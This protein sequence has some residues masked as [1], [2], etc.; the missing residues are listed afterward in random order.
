M[1]AEGSQ[2]FPRPDPHGGEGRLTASQAAA[3]EY[4]ESIARERA[5]R[6]EGRIAETLED[7]ALHLPLS[8]LGQGVRRVGRITLNFHPDRLLASGP[9]VAEALLEEGT[10]RNQF[11]TG[12]S[13]GG[14]T[15]YAGG[16]RDEWERGMFNGAYHNDGVQ[17][18]DRPKYG[19]L[20]L[21]NHPDGAC[22]RFG[23]C[24]L[25]LREEALA[26]ATYSFGDSVFHPDDVGTIDAFSSVLAALLE[27]CRRNGRVLGRSMDAASLVNLLLQGT[28]DRSGLAAA[29]ANGHALDDYIEAQIHGPVDL[30]EDVDLLVADP[31]FQ[32]TKIGE[33]LAGAATRFGFTLD[34]HRGYQIGPGDIPPGFRT[35]HLR[36][37]AGRVADDFSNGGTLNA[38]VIGRAARSIAVDFTRWADWETP[39]AALQHV[40]YL[41]HALVRF[42][43][44]QTGVRI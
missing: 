44:A 40:K 10:Y 31:S 17:D 3:L 13:N 35:P 34:W 26:R 41:W 2:G 18:A 12:I 36:R 15:A 11:E 20:N 43:R 37:F 14:L 1:T 24:H 9:T 42:G 16:D 21:V 28:P 32:D 4:V 22:P 8:R 23:S 33:D 39:H 7:A 29:R 19:G 38:A 6:A 5:E 27:S 30:A 25:R